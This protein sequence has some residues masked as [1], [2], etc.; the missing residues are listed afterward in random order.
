MKNI[1]L[2]GIIILILVIGLVL[3]SVAM[4]FYK[5]KPSTTI[6]GGELTLRQGEQIPTINVKGESEFLTQPD[7]ADMYIK[8]ETQGKTAEEAQT[9]NRDITNAVMSSLKKNSI[10]SEDIGTDRY[11]LNPQYDWERGRK[12]IGYTQQHVLKVETTK[13]DKVGEIIDDAVAAGANSI[14]RI[15]FGLSLEK[16][17]EVNKQALELAG[18]EANKKAESIAGAMGVELGKIFTISESGTSPV[19]P[20]RGY[21]EMAVAKAGMDEMAAPTTISPE[22]ITVRAYVSVAYEIE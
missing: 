22:D 19:Y 14:E 12:I 4:V 16:K 10:K 8:I 15:Q 7:K 13:L 11:Y 17:Y 3:T 20:V 21:A 18:K 5:P 6:A 2:S 9:Q 1:G